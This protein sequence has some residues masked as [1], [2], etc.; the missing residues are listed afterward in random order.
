MIELQ[1]IIVE[2][3]IV[4]VECYASALLSIS[5]GAPPYIVD[6]GG[7]NSLQKSVIKFRFYLLL[8]YFVIIKIFHRKVLESKHLLIIMLEHPCHYYPGVSHILILTAIIIIA[9]C[10][11]SF[12]FLNDI[13]YLRHVF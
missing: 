13:L 8:F 10:W 2:E 11:C 4:Q 6:W 7:A 1:E 3:S 12:C 5:G 9:L